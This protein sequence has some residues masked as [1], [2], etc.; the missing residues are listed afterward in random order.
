MSWR[1]RA[2]CGDVGAALALPRVVPDEG[3]KVPA[4]AAEVPLLLLRGREKD[5]GGASSCAGAGGGGA[6]AAVAENERGREDAGDVGLLLLFADNDLDG[7]GAVDTPA[8][9]ALAVWETL[10][11]TWSCITDKPT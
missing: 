7:R 3:E 4:V 10:S 9:T 6:A 8:A 2:S 11:F 1:G 5:L